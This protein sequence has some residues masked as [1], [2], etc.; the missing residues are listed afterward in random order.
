MAPGTVTEVI[1]DGIDPRVL[2]CGEHRWR[3]EDRTPAGYTAEQS[4]RMGDW[5]I[6]DICQECRAIRCDRYDDGDERCVEA[7]HH[8]CAHRFRSGGQ[9]AVGE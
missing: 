4:L 3:L 9:V 6:C 2:A 7:R 5:Y 1:T 8:R